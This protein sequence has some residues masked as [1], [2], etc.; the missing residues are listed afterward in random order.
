MKIKDLFLG[1]SG[2]DLANL[3][4]DSTV[5]GLVEIE[6]QNEISKKLE[7]LKKVVSRSSANGYLVIAFKA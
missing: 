5:V 7:E 1:K 2:A 4:K 6:I 3:I